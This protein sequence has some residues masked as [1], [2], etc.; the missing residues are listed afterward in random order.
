MTVN[1]GING[2][3][4]IGRVFYRAALKNPNIRVVAINDLM[5]ADT[6]AHLLKYDTVH[7]TLE[8]EV[9]RMRR[10]DPRRRQPRRD[11]L[12]QGAGQDRLEGLRGGHRRRVH[13]PVHQTRRCR[14]APQPPGRAR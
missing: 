4:R 8:A 6:M 3:G 10:L 13:R 9:A 2:F 1:V 5:N 7:G 14:A 12:R 11:S